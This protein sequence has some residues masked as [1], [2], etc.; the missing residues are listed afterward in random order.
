MKDLEKYIN[1][2]K[3]WSMKTFGLGM[4]TVGLCKHIQKELEEIQNDPVDV[5][6]WCDII[7]LALDGAWRAGYTSEEITKA[8]I[9]K[10]IVNF[11]RRWS[12][13][14]PQD[15]YIEHI[16]EDDRPTAYKA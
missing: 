13:T 14:K 7:I 12:L 5:S 2:Q 11:R 4:R 16:R 10:Q 1:R 6:E 15:E 8:L 9:E 3:E